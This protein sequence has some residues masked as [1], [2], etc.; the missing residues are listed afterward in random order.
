MQQVPVGHPD[1]IEEIYD[2]ISYLK[3]ASIIRMLHNYIGDE[4]N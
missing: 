4:V 3:G 1:E 2:D